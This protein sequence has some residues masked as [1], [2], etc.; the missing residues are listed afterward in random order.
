MKPVSPIGVAEVHIHEDDEGLRVIYPATELK[1][2]QLDLSEAEDA[3]EQNLAPNGVGWTDVHVIEAPSVSLTTLA[4]P[5]FQIETLVTPHLPR[6]GRYIATAFGGFD[7]SERDPYGVYL[8][9]PW[10]FGFDSS[11]FLL[12]TGEGKIASDIWFV[13]ETSNETHLAALN[14]AFLA[15][16]NAWPLCLADYVEDQCGLLSDQDF[17]DQYFTAEED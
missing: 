15:L 2:A 4:M 11:C 13:K 17:L 12:V 6:I 10:C 3:A 7:R 1:A 9:D 14:T 5:L 8:D 16:S